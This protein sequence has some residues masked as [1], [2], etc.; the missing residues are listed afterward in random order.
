LFRKMQTT[1]KPAL[2]YFSIAARAEIP[3]LILVVAGVDHD[4]H[5]LKYRETEG[6]DWAEYKQRHADALTFGQVPRY[7]D[8]TVD[9][10]QSMAI[11][12]YLARK[13]GLNGDNENE[14][15]LIDV[16]NEGVSDLFSKWVTAKFTGEEAKR[17]EA[18]A[19]FTNEVFPVWLGY[20]S[21]L[22]EKNN[23]TFLVG[24]RLSYADLHLFHAL[25]RLSAEPGAA[26]ILAR[27]S[28]KEFQGKIAAI[29][30]IKAYYDAKPYG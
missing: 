15:T 28:I 23:K 18:V 14:T 3:R 10:V 5:K 24:Q 30:R 21:K 27:F 8:E 26:D 12:R 13:Y 17:E 19:K 22:Y 16:A 2:T 9:I 11:T 20:F 25:N 6:A 7:Q 4:F 1:H 29:P